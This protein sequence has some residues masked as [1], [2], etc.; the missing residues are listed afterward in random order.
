[1]VS[2]VVTQFKQAAVAQRTM[3]PPTPMWRSQC[4]SAEGVVSWEGVVESEGSDE[5]LR[6]EVAKVVVL[7]N[8]IPYTHV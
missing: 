4:S 5:N 2:H 1:M 3:A 6:R 8:M 7:F